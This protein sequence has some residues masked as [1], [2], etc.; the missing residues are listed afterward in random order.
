MVCLI[1][2][3]LV[4]GKTQEEHDRHLTAVLQKVAEAGI[5]LNPDNCEFCKEIRFL[6]QLADR[7]SV[8]TLTVKAIQQMKQP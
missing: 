5:T 4:Y 3:I 2:D 6:G 7:A 1:D 8:L